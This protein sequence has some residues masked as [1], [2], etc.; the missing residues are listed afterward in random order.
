MLAP[1]DTTNMLKIKQSELRLYCDL[2]S[3]QTHELKNIV[4][5][6]KQPQQEAAT[7]TPLNINSA[8][9]LTN[10]QV[11]TTKSTQENDTSLNKESSSAA[12]SF[13]SVEN[14]A[15]EIEKEDNNLLSTADDEM[16]NTLDVN[17]VKVRYL[18]NDFFL[19]EWTRLDPCAN[20][21]VS[22]F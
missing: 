15:T 13:K 16:N 3:Q 2:L 19:V 17:N 8:S 1:L 10:D 18:F 5:T 20:Q 4:N 11:A 6:Q 21:W 14:L 12:S 7:S 22:F 9:N